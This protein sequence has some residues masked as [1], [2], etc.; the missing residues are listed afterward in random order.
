MFGLCLCKN[1]KLFCLLGVGVGV[2]PPQSSKTSNQL[3]ESH[4]LGGEVM[5]EG[6]VWGLVF[7]SWTPSPD[8]SLCGRRRR[9]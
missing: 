8:M 1:L 4:L 5:R 6:Q 3:P 2:L 7:E 9:E